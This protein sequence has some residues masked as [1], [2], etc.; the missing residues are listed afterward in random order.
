VAW[1]HAG[2][3]LADSS[4]PTSLG[5]EQGRLTL[6]RFPRPGPVPPDNPI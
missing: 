6:K 1:I 4:Q 2:N 3:H 5:I